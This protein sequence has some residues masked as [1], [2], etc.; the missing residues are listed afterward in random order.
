MARSFRYLTLALVSLAFIYTYFWPTR[1]RPFPKYQCTWYVATKRADVWFWLPNTGADAYKWTEIA[2]ERDIP[3]TIANS[4]DFSIYDVKSGD[5][6]TLTGG[7]YNTNPVLGHV[8]YIESVDYKRST[9]RV[10]EYFNGLYQERNLVVYA[11][12][13]MSFVHKPNL[14]SPFYW[15]RII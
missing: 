4:A 10:S 3:V 11:T 5:I 15:L 6:L 9:I 14:F 12:P 13:N 1:T 7:I 2:E 8:A